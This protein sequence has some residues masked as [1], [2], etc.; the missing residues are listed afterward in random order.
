[1]TLAALLLV[2]IG[3]LGLFHPQRVTIQPASGLL[4]VQGGETVYLKQGESLGLR[5]EGLVVDWFA[6]RKLHSSRAV[7][8]EGSLIVRLANGFTRRYDGHLRVSVRDGELQLVLR[9][10][11]ERIVA[12]IADAESPPGAPP[13]A[14]EA[15]AILAR[16]WLAAARRRHTDFDFCD[17]T[18]CQHFKEST[19]QGRRAAEATRGHVLTWQDQPFAAAYS[20]SCGGRTQ[21]VSSIGWEERIT[22]PY[23]AVDCP[24]CEES[25]PEWTRTFDEQEAKLLRDA[26]QSE[27]ARIRIGRKLGWNAL[28]GNL[29]RIE[30]TPQ[31]LVVHGRGQGHGLGYCQRGGAGLAR[32]GLRAKEILL[33]YFPG[34][35]LSPLTAR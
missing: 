16:S 14:L 13:A 19:P 5:R 9:T 24:V 12:A 22:Y 15:Q 21:T 32:R 35:A 25:E 7:S 3:I 31:G 34:A 27:S 6:H 2:E 17:T 4:S 11:P 8:I 26:P 23:R 1:M 10:D 28:P 33:H 29:Y 20:A 30:E 18:H